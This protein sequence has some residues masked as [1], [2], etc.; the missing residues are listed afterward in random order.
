MKAFAFSSFIF[1]FLL[2]LGPPLP[3]AIY[4]FSMLEMDGD[5]YAIGGYASG[6]LSAIYQL[7]CSSGVCSWTTLDQQLKVARTYPVAIPVQDNSCT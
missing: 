5:V 4:R 6:H 2:T 3:K 1:P 7:S